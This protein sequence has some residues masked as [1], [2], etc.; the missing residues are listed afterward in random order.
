MK[1]RAVIWMRGLVAVTALALAGCSSSG[2]NG[3]V[4]EATY[5]DGMQTSSAVLQETPNG[6]Y[7]TISGDPQ[8]IVDNNIEPENML[9]YGG[10]AEGI[11][12]AED[13][14][15]TYNGM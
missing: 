13:E 5:F 4:D 2:S 14:S 1:V 3:T 15:T 6:G 9:P 10:G 8:V 12:E 11:R 7:R